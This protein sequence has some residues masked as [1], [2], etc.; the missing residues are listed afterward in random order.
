MMR[1][2]RNSTR[3]CIMGCTDYGLE[4][5]KLFGTNSSFSVMVYDSNVEKIEKQRQDEMGETKFE[6]IIS[7]IFNNNFFIIVDVN[8]E[9]YEQRPTLVDSTFD[10]I[11]ENA[12]PGSVIVIESSLPIGT[13][14][15]YNSIANGTFV[16]CH[17]PIRWDNERANVQFKNIPKVISAAN[18]NDLERLKGVYGAVFNQVVC[19]SSYEAAEASNLL[20][21]AF[22]V[23]N[24]SFI[25]EFANACKEEDINPYEVLDISSTKP[26]GFMEF[27]PKLGCGGP[28]VRKESNYLIR[29]GGNVSWPI[30]TM[31]LGHL[32][33]RPELLAKAMPLTYKHILL[34]GVGYKP[35]SSSWEN[36][37]VIP[38][39]DALKGRGAEVDYVDP[40]IR[41]FNT[42]TSVDLPLSDPDHYDCIVV[43]HPYCL[44]YWANPE[45]KDKVI[46]YCHH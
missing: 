25:N 20:E 32:D 40:F 11:R 37:P 3:V 38:F 2:Q 26:F 39:I 31:A 9:I 5:A 44:S 7:R 18:S 34:V 8:D 33:K 22:R 29:S 4:L 21:S 17:S 24:I 13:S 1:E 16:V 6:Y 12:S 45:F 14:R 42:I 19:A 41:D 30:L 46:Y 15:K 23:L 35:N 43:N 28:H 10:L 36:S 27:T